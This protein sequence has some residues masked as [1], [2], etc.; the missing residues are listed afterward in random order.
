MSTEICKRVTLASRPDGMPT[1]ENFA[2]EEVE[3]LPLGEDQVTVAVRYLSV[4]AFIRTTLE[5]GGIHATSP[6]GGPVVALGVG[7][8]I[9]STSELKARRRTAM[10][11]D[12][13]VESVDVP[14]RPARP[15][16]AMTATP[17]RPTAAIRSPLMPTSAVLGGPP[18]PS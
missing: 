15:S 4:D 14:A 5:E 2:L 9:D 11:E 7:E 3:L 17:A 18:A 8:V 12:L 6:I 13:E 16:R 10:Y 1:R